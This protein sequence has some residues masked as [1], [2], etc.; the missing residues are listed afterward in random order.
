MTLLSYLIH[1]LTYYYSI[2]HFER[3]RH[4]TFWEEHKST[5]NSRNMERKGVLVFICHTLYSSGKGNLMSKKL[6]Q[7]LISLIKE[8]WLVA[9]ALNKNM[10]SDVAIEKI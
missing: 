9:I 2:Y 6:L 4:C 8:S 10:V 7:P 3:L 5:K 1:F